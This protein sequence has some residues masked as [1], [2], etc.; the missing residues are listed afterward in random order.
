[1]DSL[2]SEQNAVVTDVMAQLG[3]TE[4]KAQEQ[5]ERIVELLGADRTYAILKKTLD[6]EK[7]GGIRTH[8]RKR[9]RSPGGVFFFLVR[10]RVSPKDHATIWPHLKYP[11]PRGD[12]PPIKPMPESWD[13]HAEILAEAMAEQGVA[14]K[15]KITLVGRPGR[16]IERG[17]VV[18]VTMT[19]KEVPALPQGL[20]APPKDATVYLVYIVRQQWEKIAEA[21]Q[22]TQNRLSVEGYPFNAKK[23]GVI[24][25]LTQRVLVVN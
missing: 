17:N 16:I 3:E 10:G 4:E 8:N 14:K 2:V 7:K 21:M 22:N 18:I 24:G 6:I 12:K 9:R 11:H 5:I 19:N 20:P 15:V 1:M 25:V 13:D 23:L